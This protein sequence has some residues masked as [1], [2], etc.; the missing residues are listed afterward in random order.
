MGV[1]NHSSKLSLAGY[2]FGRHPKDRLPEARKR[3]LY[4]FLQFAK[5]FCICAL[6][7]IVLNEAVFLVHGPVA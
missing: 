3:R 4:G 5:S 1:N 2:L 7:D 6:E